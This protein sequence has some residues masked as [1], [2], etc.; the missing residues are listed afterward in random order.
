MR[1]SLF[2]LG[3]ALA[4]AVHA[5]AAI[6]QQTPYGPFCQS[7]M[8]EFSPA[9]HYLVARRGSEA[10]YVASTD[11]LLRRGMDCPVDKIVNNSTF[12]RGQIYFSNDDQWVYMTGA[13]VDAREKRSTGDNVIGKFVTSAVLSANAPPVLTAAFPTQGDVLGYLDL[14]VELGTAD[15]DMLLSK[16]ALQINRAAAHLS[17]FSA[18]SRNLYGLMAGKRSIYLVRS[19]VDYSVSYSLDGGPER[20]LWRNGNPFSQRRANLTFKFDGR[21]AIVQTSGS[22]LRISRKGL[23]DM[24]SRRSRSVLINGDDPTRYYGYGSAEGLAASSVP[25]ELAALLQASFARHR[26]QHMRGLA[27]NET[28]GATVFSYGSFRGDTGRALTRHEIRRGDRVVEITCGGETLA[29]HEVVRVG[30]DRLFVDRYRRTGARPTLLYLTGGPG[31]HINLETEIDNDIA[32]LLDNGFNVDVL[33]YGGT[34]YTFAQYNR[35]YRSG[36]AALD[37]NAQLIEQYV[38]NTYGPDDRLSLYAFSFGAYHIRRFNAAFLRRMDHVVLA[39]PAGTSRLPT[40]S[41]PGLSA[42]YLAGIRRLSVAVN[43]SLWGPG[44]MEAEARYFQ[45]LKTCPLLVPVTMTIGQKDDTVRPL[46]DYRTCL[47]SPLLRLIH[48]PSGHVSGLEPR[49]TDLSAQV[50]AVL[51]EP[52]VTVRPSGP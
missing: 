42:D 12:G 26:D 37:E 17:R 46:E 15:M 20:P 40:Y 48:H 41:S 43:R 44:T 38:A 18:N 6:A 39:A 21:D 36:P 27:F 7:P 1:S 16:Q 49:L 13:G 11:C 50:I 9:G 30:R 47:N 4:L 24:T 28:I 52:K 2:G 19:D 51:K 33:Q 31:G 10:V 35:L 29:E 23:V 8:V 3:I 45:N 34:D 25:A 14:R 22:I 5:Q 32:A